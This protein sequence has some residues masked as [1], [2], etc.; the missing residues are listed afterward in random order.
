MRAINIHTAGSFVRVVRD[1]GFEESKHPRANNGQFGAGGAGKKTASN[2]GSS[3]SKEDLG[4]LEPHPESKMREYTAK[5]LDWEYDVEY[6]KY[7]KS[8]FP[9][10]F[11]SREDFQKKYDDAP[12]V[13]L[14]DKELATLGN[15]MAYAGKNKGEEWVHKTFSHRRDSKR[16]LHEM[17]NEKTAPPI[18]LKRDGRLRLMAGQTRLATG[19]ALGMSVPAKIIDVTKK[20][21]DEA[22]FE[23]SKHPRAK[24]GQFGKGGGGSS[25]P[26]KI[27]TMQGKGNKFVALVN[28][29]VATGP[30]G[31]ELQFNSPEEAHEIMGGGESEQ[32]KNYTANGKAQELYKALAAPVKGSSPERVALRKLLK[33][34]TDKAEQQKIKDKI[35]QSFL[36]QHVA[37]TKK[38]DHTKAAQLMGKMQKLGYKPPPPANTAQ[39]NAG[40]SAQNISV[41]QQV[42]KSV[43]PSAQYSPEEM[44]S[45]NDLVQFTGGEKHAKRCAAEAK[46]KLA[47]NPQIK[48]SIA[49]A[50][51]IY[52]YT[53]N[54]YGKTNSALREGIMDEATWKHVSHL[55]KALDKL[56]NHVG[57]VRRRAELSPNVLALYKPGMIVEER[58]FTST[59]THTDVN[60]SASVYHIKSKTG[61]NVRPLSEWPGEDEILFKSGSRFKIDKVVDKKN[62]QKEIHMTEMV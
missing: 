39:A 12:L 23:E 43:S 48:M 26:K 32:A 50:S 13:H 44:Q 1:D 34:S 49:E 9:G 36:V 61:K 56:P 55:N 31:K 35:L 20:T 42:A 14:S 27:E 41:A 19:L 17:K 58:G 52:A 11:S 30:D 38:G 15:S 21:K 25:K 59:T 51:H 28:G 29:K 45:F 60:T 57:D 6:L 4:G 62:G 47:N 37:V 22:P 16:I 46:H 24:N 54:Y 40:Y 53:D 2:S 18:I 7:A 3:Q 5:E 8:E 33:A 10:A